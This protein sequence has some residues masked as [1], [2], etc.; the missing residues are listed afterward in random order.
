MVMP[1]V[2]D[3]HALIWYMTDDP[4]LSAAARDI[5]ERVDTAQERVF[6]PCIV[7]FE[8]LY[9]VEKNRIGVDFDSVVSMVSSSDNYDV[10]PLYLRIIEES[11][12]IPMERVKDP[13]DRLIAATSMHLGLPLITRDRSL[14]AVIETIW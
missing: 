12:R 5:F 13:W 7:F 9:L 14:Q 4:N 11:R 10:E 3:T 2:T 6:I 1:Y 8:L